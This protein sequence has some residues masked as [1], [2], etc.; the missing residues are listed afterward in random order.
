[1]LGKW[2]AVSSGFHFEIT[3][4]T[5][6]GDLNGKIYL[7]HDESPKDTFPISGRYDDL[8]KT[9]GFVAA[10]YNGIVQYYSTTSYVLSVWET[11]Q[12]VMKCYWLKRDMKK[13]ADQW[14]DTV[15]GVNLFVHTAFD[16]KTIFPDDSIC[17]L[18]ENGC[19][20]P[21]QLPKE[22]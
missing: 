2:Q 19:S 8:A 13:P 5:P 17:K 4:V 6:D 16:V 22:A 10:W 3:T 14:E 15:L 11:D 1:M 21:V 7:T 9:W 20:H 12:N 18:L